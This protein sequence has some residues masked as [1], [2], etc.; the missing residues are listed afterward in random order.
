MNHF[1]VLYY[2]ECKKL[3]NKKFVMVLSELLHSNIAALAISTALLFMAMI[4]H[5]PKQ[6]RVLA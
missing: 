5:V 6:Y 2:Y 3:L 4:V 1:G